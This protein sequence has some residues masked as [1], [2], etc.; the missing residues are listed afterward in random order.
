MKPGSLAALP[1]QGRG[2]P[3]SLL[4]GPRPRII[5]PRQCG[6]VLGGSTPW[7]GSRL[8]DPGG[9]VL[10]K[11]QGP[12]REKETSGGGRDGG[13]A[14]GAPIWEEASSRKNRPPAGV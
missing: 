3:T 10:E 8:V 7:T 1:W 5:T 6:P 13:P 14:P 11:S 4:A 2:L 9:P 12:G